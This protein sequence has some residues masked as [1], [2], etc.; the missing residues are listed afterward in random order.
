MNESFKCQER[1]Q[2]APSFKVTDA[3]M[4]RREG[5]SGKNVLVLSLIN[6]FLSQFDISIR[7]V[8]GASLV[9]G[10]VQ[11][12]LGGLLDHDDSLTFWGATHSYHWDWV[13]SPRNYFRFSYCLEWQLLSLE[14]GSHRRL[15]SSSE[16]CR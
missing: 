7:K 14:I 8:R 1:C 13:D 12:I 4:I 6:S 5:R 11:L 16:R 15:K 2:I 3:K 9:L 10:L